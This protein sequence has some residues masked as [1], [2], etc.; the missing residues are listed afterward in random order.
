MNSETP[1]DEGTGYQIG[2][3]EATEIRRLF[4]EVQEHA[5]QIQRQNMIKRMKYGKAAKKAQR[6]QQQ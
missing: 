3:G 5:A 6:E 1:N 4:E 2:P